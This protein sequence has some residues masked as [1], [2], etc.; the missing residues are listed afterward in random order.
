MGCSSQEE[1][2]VQEIKETKATKE[3]VTVS[4]MNQLDLDVIEDNNIKPYEII[5]PKIYGEYNNKGISISQINNY[6]GNTYIKDLND[7]IKMDASVE[8]PNIQELNTYAYVTK[9]CDST[10][11]NKVIDGVFEQGSSLFM[12]NAKNPGYFEYVYGAGVGDYYL[13]HTIFP[14][15]GPTVYG[16]MAFMLSNAA[17]NLYPFEDNI[18]PESDSFSVAIKGFDP[19]DTAEQVIRS[20]DYYNGWEQQYFVPYGNHGRNTFFRIV[21][22]MKQDNLYVNAYNDTYFLVDQGGIETF[23][24]TFFDLVREGNIE[25]VVTLE[26]AIDILATRIFETEIAQYSGVVIDRIS[27]EY[28]VTQKED[29]SVSCMPYWRFYFKY[30]EYLKRENQNIICGVNMVNREFIYEERGFWF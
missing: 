6:K 19:F 28:V 26:D 22:K 25:Q 4:G 30:D 9:I 8:I 15:A 5:F 13:Y 14:C 24:G 29:G 11:R 1:S 2:K 20:I 18:V 21:Y 12:E 23:T 7:G 17:P 10:V 27:I 16:E 3:L